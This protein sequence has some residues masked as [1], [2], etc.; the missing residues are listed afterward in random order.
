[1]K[2]LLL[3]TKLSALAL[4]LLLTA[5]GETQNTSSPQ[6]EPSDSPA[7]SIAYY[8]DEV[9]EQELADEPELE[10][11]M[12]LAKDLL[13]SYLHFSVK[14]KKD[15]RSPEFIYRAAMLQERYFENFDEAFHLYS[16]ITDDYPESPQAAKAMF[17]KGMIMSEYYQKCDKAIYYFDEFKRKYPEHEMVTMAQQA[18]DV[19]GMSA[20]E[21]FER[22]QS[23]D[24]IGKKAVP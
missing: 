8:I 6:S 19:C 1:M 9:L 20:E 17:M 11:R 24:T 14:Y 15:E 4:A 12:V 10:N 13:K 16:S 21:I 7:D 2:T 5:C 22:I 3:P 18:I 23:K